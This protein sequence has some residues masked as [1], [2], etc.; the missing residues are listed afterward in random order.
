MLISEL[1]DY[2]DA[3][4][5]PNGYWN[6]I[7]RRNTSMDWPDYFSGHWARN[8]HSVGDLRQLVEQARVT[9]E[10]PTQYVV[11]KPIRRNPSHQHDDGTFEVLGRQAIRAVALST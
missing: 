4:D 3:A 2:D 8:R 1:G 10:E 5:R 6:Q 9:D 11:H 7:G